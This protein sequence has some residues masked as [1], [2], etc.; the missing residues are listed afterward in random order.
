MSGVGET[1]RLL[2]LRGR[3]SDAIVPTPI[4]LA[5]P[6]RLTIMRADT[7]T[8]MPRAVSE[9]SSIQ[10]PLPSEATVELLLRVREGDA[11]A[12]DELLERSIPRLR[13]W[14]HGRLPSFARDLHDTVDL[15]QDAV[16]AGI[17]RLGTLEIRHE[18]ALQAYL[19]QC[20]RNRIIDII[21]AHKRRPE[22][23]PLSDDLIDDG[24]SPLALAIGREGMQRY[25]AALNRLSDAERQAVILKLELGYSNAEA[26]VALGKPTA[27]AA[28]VAI[29]RACKRLTELMSGGF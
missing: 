26:A 23:V 3:R 11:A 10:P 17:R 25:E 14:A 5:E 13:K 24:T 12:L 20:V 15:V 16:I 29:S 1:G 2:K 8:P 22:A 27:E 4:R 9:S 28:R 21:R 19:R 7:V 6:E 18:G